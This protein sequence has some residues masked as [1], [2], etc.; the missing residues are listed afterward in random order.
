MAEANPG[1]HRAPSPRASK[2]TSQKGGSKRRS[3]GRAPAQGGRSKAKASSTRP[4][5]RA[6]RTRARQRSGQASRAHSARPSNGRSTVES[7]TEAVSSGA[8]STADIAR[9]AKGPLIA[10]AVTIAGLAGAAALNGRSGR[11]KVLGVKMPR[12]NGLGRM[13][14]RK[15]LKKVDARKTLN[16][17]DARKVAGSVTDAAKRADRFGRRV[18]SVA[19]SVRTVSETAEKAAKKA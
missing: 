5:Q 9:K 2:S 12:A 1:Q 17:T 16:N 18:S 13:D 10:G 11:R 7:L 6:S 4:R 15:A 14:V 8:E 3:N 19:N